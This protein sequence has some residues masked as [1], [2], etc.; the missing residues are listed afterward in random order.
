MGGGGGLFC[1]LNL[2]V[3]TGV[4]DHVYLPDAPGPIECFIFKKIKLPYFKMHGIY[5]YI[6][7]TKCSTM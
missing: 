5:S 3:R 4:H 2:L 7:F 6:S 1:C